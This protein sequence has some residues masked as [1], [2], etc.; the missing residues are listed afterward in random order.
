[1]DTYWIS[2]YEKKFYKGR[3]NMQNNQ[4][5]KK[6]LIK[7]RE[8]IQEDLLTLLDDSSETIKDLVCQIVVENFKKL[9][10]KF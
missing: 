5:E 6:M 4:Q 10:K 3:Q 7:C 9:E 1:M 2:R 8:Q